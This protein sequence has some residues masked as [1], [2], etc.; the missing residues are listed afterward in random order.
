MYWE[1]RQKQV[2]YTVSD[3]DIG[4]YSG[5]KSNT[6][7]LVVKFR[8][9]HSFWAVPEGV[10]CSVLR[11]LSH[12][13]SAVSASSGFI[14]ISRCSPL[15][16]KVLGDCRTLWGTGHW[17]DRPCR[18]KSCV[19]HT[20]MSWFS[21]QKTICKS[22][23]VLWDSHMV[24]E[25]GLTELNVACVCTG[26]MYAYVCV[27]MFILMC[28]LFWLKLLYFLDIVKEILWFQARD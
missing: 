25:N 3:L 1:S 13:A 21:H 23:F 12:W 24:C 19:W 15:V 9:L 28:A 27:F 8:K 16:P 18:S 14:H 22:R 26:E 7:I 6:F 2:N 17:N 5:I 20:I 4:I 10:S 11:M